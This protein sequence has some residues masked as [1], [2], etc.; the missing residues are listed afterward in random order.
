MK[1]FRIA[2]AAA[3][4][5]AFWILA[6]RAAEWLNY[7]FPVSGQSSGSNTCTGSVGAAKVIPQIAAGSFGRVLK[8]IDTESGA[9]VATLPCV[10]GVDDLWFEILGADEF[11]QRPRMSRILY[12]G[13]LYD[14][15]LKP[16]NALRN[17]GPVEAVRC[18]SSYGWAKVRPPKDT[19]A[20]PT[21]RCASQG[22]PS[23]H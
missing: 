2:L 6:P 14:Y 22:R 11:L 21:P 23:G 19:S 1:A 20:L 12:R 13:K 18:V 15:P 4:T 3:I 7:E 16:L 8:V 17:L 9:V 10:L 5:I